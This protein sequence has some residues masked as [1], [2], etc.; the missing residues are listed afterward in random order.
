[1]LEDTPEEAEGRVRLTS[2]ITYAPPPRLESR[3]A[4]EV[5]AALRAE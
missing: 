2:G 4:K 3:W 5:L 1:V